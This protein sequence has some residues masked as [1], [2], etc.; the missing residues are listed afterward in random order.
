MG[1]TREKESR[2]TSSPAEKKDRKYFYCYCYSFLKHSN[3]RHHG[4]VPSTVATTVPA[5]E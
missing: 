3:N 1:A 4:I 2:I 5:V